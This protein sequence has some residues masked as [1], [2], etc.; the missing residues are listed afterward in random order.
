[1][2]GMT[3][4]LMANQ[5][6]IAAVAAGLGATLL[7]SETL[8]QTVKWVGVAYLA[9]IGLQ[10]L[11]SRGSMPVAAAEI[12]E[13]AALRRT[14]GLEQ[15]RRCLIVAVTNPKGLV[16]FSALF[17]QF[18]N[19]TQAPAIQYLTLATIF[20]LIDAAV[21]LAYAAL[22]ANAVAA[23]SQ[24]A[25]RWLDRSLGAALLTLAACIALVTRRNS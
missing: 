13:T 20:A 14:R 10:L 15:F 6:L 7:T 9:W 5:L 24:R 11:R 3:G 2:P 22:G 8:F 18:V 19:P 23:I 4:S 17:P 1:M 16:F 21:L 12:D 25:A